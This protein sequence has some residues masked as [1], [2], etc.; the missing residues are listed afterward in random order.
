VAEL[1]LIDEF[2]INDTLLTIETSKRCVCHCTW[3]HVEL[4]RR[5]NSASRDVPDTFASVVTAAF[6]NSYDPTDFRQYS[7]RNGLPINW[8]MGVEP[9]QDVVEARAI[10]DT[11]ERLGLRFTFQSRGV[12]WRSVWD[13]VKQFAGNSAIAISL[14]TDDDAWIKRFE[15][16][17]PK[18]SERIAL[19]EA[20]VDAGFAVRL[21]AA[22]YHREWCEDFP[23]LIRRAIGWGVKQVFVDP[24]RLNHEQLAASKD[25]ELPRLCKTAWSEE[26]I[27]QIEEARDICVEAGISWEC[28]NR[29]AWIN[30]VESVDP[31]GYLPR[32]R[33]GY[34]DMD[35]LDA[36]TSIGD[37]PLLIE[38]DT[39][40]RIMEERGAIDQP[41]R[42]SQF[43]SGFRCFMNTPLDWEAVLKPAAPFREYLRYAWNR[44]AVNGFVWRSPFIRS[45]V[46]PDGQPWLSPTGDLILV[47][48]RFLGSPKTRQMIECID[49]CEYLSWGD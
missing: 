48:D 7:V 32:G 25:H 30:G 36:V 40:R 37:G 24:L 45:A 10:L 9:W 21:A 3:C 22:P 43:R 27:K 13:Q 46:R 31:C 2:G 16:G 42:W 47:F 35:V 26:A 49:D 38:W 20:A 34:Y 17:T 18:A 12:N 39:A 5:A 1:R 33:F 6:G 4:T 44:P 15:P 29:Q 41:F 8:A 28:N 14:P 23:G 19:I 11:A